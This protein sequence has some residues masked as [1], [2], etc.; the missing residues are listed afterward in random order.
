MNN[1]ERKRNAFDT[2]RKLIEQDILRLDITI[3]ETAGMEKIIL[4]FDNFPSFCKFETEYLKD[5]TND[6]QRR[7]MLIYLLL[8]NALYIQNMQKFNSRVYFHYELPQ[9][10]S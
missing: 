6:A 10:C 5:T 7:E 9:W 1:L 2:V 4:R 8:K 3:Q